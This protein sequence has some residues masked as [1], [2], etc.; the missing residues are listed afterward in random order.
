MCSTTIISK[1]MG[2]QSSNKLIFPL[3]DED[4][5]LSDFRKA[6]EIGESSSFSTK[7]VVQ[8][9]L[10]RS[11]IK[12]AKSERTRLGSDIWSVSDQISGFPYV[13]AGTKVVARSK[14]TPL[15]DQISDQ[16]PVPPLSGFF[17]WFLF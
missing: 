10:A 7:M 5:Q 1:V 8:I 17:I 6:S 4:F 16:I 9:Y 3:T 15:S 12:S 13:D 14:L 11:Q 2:C